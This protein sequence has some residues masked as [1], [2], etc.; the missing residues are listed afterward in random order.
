[1]HAIGRFGTRVVP[2]LNRIFQECRD[3]KQ[4]ELESDSALGRAAE[5]PLLNLIPSLLQRDD[6]QAARH[7]YSR[8]CT[9]AARSTWRW[10]AARSRKRSSDPI[11]RHRPAPC[12]SCSGSGMMRFTCCRSTPPLQAA[13]WMRQAG[14][15]MRAEGEPRTAGRSSSIS[16]FPPRASRAVALQE[17]WRGIGATVSVTT[18]E[19]AVFQ[20]RLGEGQFDAYIGAYLDEPSPRGLAD[21]WTQK[22]LEALNYGSYKSASFDSL[23]FRALAMPSVAD[24]R[25][26]WREAMDTINAQ[27]PALFL[28]APTNV[29][30]VSH[31]LEGVEIDPYSWMSGLPGWR[32]RGGR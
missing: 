27:A 30:A 32:V 18:V 21:Q 16:W 24:A 26:A 15:A 28:Y 3:R 20:K 7:R 17:S 12:R 2:G 9:C 4:L 31:R 22:G 1:M 6:G 25:L 8:T 23:F 29:A 19:F 13:N 14:P 10:T 5:A 11:P